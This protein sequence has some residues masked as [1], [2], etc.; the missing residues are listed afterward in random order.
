MTL[1]DNTIRTAPAARLRVDA[2]LLDL[3]GTLVDSNDQHAK[4]WVDALAERGIRVRFED[5]RPLVGM[6]GEQLLRKL[7]GIAPDDPRSRELRDRRS[8]LFVERYL[9]EIAPQPGA[10]ELV[11]K[12][13]ERGFRLVVATSSSEDEVRPLLEI[14]GIGEL[15]DAVTNADDVARAKPAP[16]V[17]RAA[18]EKARVNEDHAVLLGDTPYDVASARQAGVAVI[19]FRCGGWDDA[20]LDGAIDVFDD[21]ADLLRNWMQTPFRASLAGLDAPL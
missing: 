20:S 4:A 5:V 13:R 6:G 16:D 1:S 17:V 14:A 9:S 21:P 11:A 12:L 15:V 19:A 18:L 2:V 7:T 3:D 8:R 10:R